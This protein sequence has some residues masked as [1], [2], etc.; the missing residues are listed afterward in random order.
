M[1]SKSADPLSTFQDTEILD[2]LNKNASHIKSTVIKLLQNIFLHFKAYLGIFGVY[3]NIND[4]W[5]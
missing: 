1:E 5:N 4:Y 3:L 2:L